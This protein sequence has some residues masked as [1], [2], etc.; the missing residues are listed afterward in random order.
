M[1]LESLENACK[2]VLESHGK[3]LSVFS[4]T[5]PVLST[6]CE[7]TEQK[8]KSIAAAAEEKEDFA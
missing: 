4:T 3:P 2:K 1:V 7:P 8:L 5:H 6:E